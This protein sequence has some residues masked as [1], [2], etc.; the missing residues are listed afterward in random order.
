MVDWA[1]VCGVASDTGDYDHETY[2]P[3][4]HTGDVDTRKTQRSKSMK[5][6]IQG[7]VEGFS[8][9]GGF[10]DVLGMS[11][12]T[13]KSTTNNEPEPDFDD[14]GNDDIPF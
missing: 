11:L 14:D 8:G 5:N 2:D 13:N 6:E 4:G 12:D 1:G 9:A 10:D 3:V 7:V